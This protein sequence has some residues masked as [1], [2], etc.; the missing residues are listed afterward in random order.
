MD[1]LPTASAATQLSGNVTSGANSMAPL[2]DYVSRINAQN[3]A[4]SAQ[5]AASLRSWQ[6]R[7]TFQANEFN[8]R[9]AAKN[10]DWQ[11][12]M[13]NTAHQREVADLKAAGLNPILSASGGNGAAV[14]SGSTAQSHNPSGAKGDTD[15]SGATAFVSLMS[16]WLQNVTQLEAQRVSAAANLAVADKYNAMTKYATDVQSRTS[17]SVAG[18]QSAASRYVAQLNLAGTKYASDQSAVTSK[19]V[20]AINYAATKYSADEHA[21]ALRYSAN[22]SALSNY[23][24]AK[25]NGEVNKELK[26]MEIDAQ[27]DLK[28]FYPGSPFNYPGSFGHLLQDSGLLSSVGDFVGGFNPFSDNTAVGTLLQS[29]LGKRWD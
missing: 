5:E 22:R 8:A 26:Q 10:R 28:K 6:E 7:M 24:V 4:H 25:I 15:M 20:A 3:N 14:T 9:E 16:S 23:M 13:S 1:S 11:Q 2:Y 29:L 19:I 18:I 17:L 12:Y 27:F 21:K